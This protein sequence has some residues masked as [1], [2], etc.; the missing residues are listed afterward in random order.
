MIGG[1]VSDET[2]LARLVVIAGDGENGVGAGRL[3]EARK[4]DRLGRRVRPG[5]GDDRDAPRRRFDAQIDEATV[6]GVAQRR[7]LAGGAA[8][9]EA[10]R[11]GLDLPMDEPLIDVLVNPSSLEG[12]DESRDGAV[13]RLHFQHMPIFNGR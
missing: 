6:L 3:G 5:A 9:N 7:R 13:K 8:G 11:P 4:L 1:E 10:V 2:R 12:R